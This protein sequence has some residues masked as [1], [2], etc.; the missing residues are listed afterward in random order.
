MDEIRTERLLMRRATMG[1]L[2]AIHALLSNPA[3]MRY[4]SSLPHTELSQSEAWLSTMVEDEPGIRDDFIVELDG[5]VIGKLGC[6]RL[7]EVGFLFAPDT[8]GNGYASEALTAY[9]DRR[10]ALGSPD[11]IRADV[12]PRNQSSINLLKR[13]GFAETHRAEGTWQIGDELCDSVYLE[14]KL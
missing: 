4:W 11:T 9:L 3:A 1:D 5:R 7:P 10:R 2:A 14:L 8:W 6:W 12:D 13:H